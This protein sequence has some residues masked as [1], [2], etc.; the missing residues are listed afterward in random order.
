MSY[1]SPHS[2]RNTEPEND[3]M[4]NDMRGVKDNPKENKRN[5]YDQNVKNQSTSSFKDNIQNKATNKESSNVNSKT[6]ENLNLNTVRKP[7]MQ[8][9]T[10]M[11][12]VGK[13]NPVLVGGIALL[14]IGAY[15]YLRKNKSDPPQSLA[16]TN[17]TS[18]SY[19]QGK[20]STSGKSSFDTPKK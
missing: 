13:M 4:T 9:S 7:K 8:F 16:T 19:T 15:Y 10:N 5:E 11:P 1:T 3:R 20:L 12:K 18:T 17:P 6:G 14:G 2:P